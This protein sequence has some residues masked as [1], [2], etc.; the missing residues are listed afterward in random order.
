MLRHVNLE[1]AT[2]TGRR[3]LVLVLIRTIR[4]DYNSQEVDP[5]VSV[6]VFD[7]LPRSPRTGL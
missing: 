7:P 3:D 6:G 2:A 1:P 4:L 5:A